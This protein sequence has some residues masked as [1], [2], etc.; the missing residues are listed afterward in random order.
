MSK[1]YQMRQIALSQEEWEFIGKCVN[2]VGC[3]FCPCQDMCYH[4][5][6]GECS[7]I[8]GSLCDKLNK[9]IEE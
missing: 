3:D 6:T 2:H 4:E 1:I 8:E 7:P 5:D 9:I